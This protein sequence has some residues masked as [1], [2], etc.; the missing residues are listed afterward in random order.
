[1]LTRKTG[2]VLLLLCC[3]YFSEGQSVSTLMGA[4]AKGLAHASACLSDEWSL[5]NNP[6]G[7][8]SLTEASFAAAY[9][10]IP[11]LPGSDRM[12]LAV[13]FPA[14]QGT[15]SAGVFRFGDMLYSEQ[16]ATVG[17]GSKLGLA[18]LGGRINVIQYSAEGFGTRSVISF[19]FGG[20]AE[21][22]PRVK[23]GAHVVN[24]NQPVISPDDGERL[25]TRLIAGVVVTPGENLLVAAEVEKDIDYK[26]TWKAGIE[27]KVFGKVSFRTGFNLFPEAAFLGIGFRS[28]RIILDYGVEYSPFMGTGHQVSA[29]YPFRSK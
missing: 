25:P 4:R 14:L 26:A 23:V 3:Y 16:I 27:Y 29:A 8:S 12:A 6:A 7:L 28:T 9:D 20:M 13:V 2:T 19:N 17:Y 10:K 11:N 1:M 21:L 5:F 18:S 24:V 15:L 22:T